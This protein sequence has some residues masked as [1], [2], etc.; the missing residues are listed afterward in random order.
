[1]AIIEKPMY[2]HDC[3]HC[4][5]LGRLSAAAAGWDL[6]AKAQGVPMDSY[7][8]Y[9]CGQPPEGKPC[10]L[11]RY[12]SGAHEFL[13]T[14]FYEQSGQMVLQGKYLPTHETAIAKAYKLATERKLFVDPTEPEKEE[15]GGGRII[16]PGE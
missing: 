12:G 6:R 1:M 8:L 13:A 5:F 4:V 7:D 11:V 15:R 9:Y 3:P 10:V 14:R 16:L 2:R